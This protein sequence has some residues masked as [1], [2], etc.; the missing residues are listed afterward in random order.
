[1]DFFFVE[2]VEDFFQFRRV[3]NVFPNLLQLLFIGR[4]WHPKSDVAVFAVLLAQ[5]FQEAVV[6]L[7]T[8]FLRIVR[9]AEL[10][11]TSE[12]GLWVEVAVGL[13]DDFPVDASWCV[14]G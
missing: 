3:G 14:G 7:G 11:G 5:V 10:D 12:N 13:G 4:T 9:Q 2:S 6:L 8:V 1:M